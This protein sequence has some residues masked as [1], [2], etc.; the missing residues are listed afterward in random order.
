MAKS[1]PPCPI[2]GLSVLTQ[3]L[4]AEGLA[5]MR[6]NRHYISSSVGKKYTRTCQRHLG[7]MMRKI[8]DGMRHGLISG[9]YTTA[10]RII[11]CTE[12]S[13]YTPS[14]SRLDNSIQRTAPLIIHNDLCSLHHRL[15]LQCSLRY[16]I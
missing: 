1:Y 15:H 9:R 6:S 3:L 4:K 12:M 2:H 16:S 11:I 7:H 8:T 14:L 5:P 10:G 13:R